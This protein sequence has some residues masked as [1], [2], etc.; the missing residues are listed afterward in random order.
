MDD[1]DAELERE[2]AS[3]QKTAQ[4]KM[5]EAKQSE[6]FLQR[7]TNPNEPMPFDWS[8]VGV[9]TGIGAALGGVTGV[10][11]V[12][13]AVGG[14]ASGVAGE[15]SRA[16]GGSDAATFG[17]ELLGGT[18]PAMTKTIAKPLI[19]A[20]SYRGGRVADMVPDSTEQIALQKA[21]EKLYGKDTI[22]VIHTTENSDAVQMSLRTELFPNAIIPENKSVSTYMR[23]SMYEKIRGLRNTQKVEVTPQGNGVVPYGQRAGDTIEVKP[24]SQIFSKSPEFKDLMTKDIK[25]LY[26]RDRISKSELASLHKIVRTDSSADPVVVA[27]ST[28]DIINLIQNGGTFV[29]EGVEQ[30]KIPE[31]AQKALRERFN[32]FLERN[33]GTQEY[34]KLKEVEK[35]EF[36]AR[37]RDTIPTLLDNKFRLGSNEYEKVLSFIKDSPEGKRDFSK[38]L[39]QHISSLKDEAQMKREFIRLRPAIAESKVMSKEELASLS[40]KI[41][42]FDKTVKSEKRLELLKQTIISPLVG[43]AASESADKVNPVKIFSL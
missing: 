34:N 38:A 30:K 32:Q 43:V 18:I 22:D 19:K 12:A 21:K 35:M 4:D 29:R 42:A 26:E 36:V 14:A 8:N 41:N 9:A 20:I 31:E 2:I 11:T 3:Y 24:D 33:L 16:L 17:A 1:F 28:E 39:L 10:G 13:G 27:T 40:S 6:T 5:K 7:I 37:A 23:E 25:A 15:V